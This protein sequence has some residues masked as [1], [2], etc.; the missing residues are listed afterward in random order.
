MLCTTAVTQNTEIQAQIQIQPANALHNCG[1]TKYTNTSTSTNT[2]TVL[3]TNE[4]TITK[5]NTNTKYKAKH[6]C[7]AHANTI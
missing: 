2:N 7:A 3:D 1:N 6:L 5:R 4:I